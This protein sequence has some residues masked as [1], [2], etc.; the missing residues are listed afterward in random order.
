MSQRRLSLRL[1]A[2][3]CLAGLTA[4]LTAQDPQ[5]TLLIK[6]GHVIDA[7]NNINAVMDVAVAGAKIVRVA[8]NI[9]PA[10]GGR[11]IDATG[12]Y[13]VPGLIDIHAHVFY[14][15]EK[16]AYLSN[17]DTAVPPDSHSFRSGQTTM[18]D[19]GG[20]GWRNFLQFKEQVIDRSR[21]RVLSLHRH[22]RIGNEGRP[23]RTGPV[24]HGREADRDA[25]PPASHPDCRHQGRA[26][27]GGPSGSGDARG[28]GRYAR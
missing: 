25:H 10:G 12:L 21:T 23:D 11:V 6:G 17:S 14:G 19:A 28:R 1:C 9:A 20:A 8:S 24:G 3:F 13:V 5:Y 26:L 4:P 22:R 27:S 7:R 18:V 16:D 15:T 2:L